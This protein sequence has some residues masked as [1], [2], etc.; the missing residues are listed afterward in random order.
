ML[1]P[2]ADVPRWY[3]ERKPKDTIAVSH[4][5]D[6]ITWEQ[7]ER[8]ANRR[9]RAFA[10]KGVKPGDFVAIGLPNSNVFFET[11]FAVWKCGATPTSLTW[12]L[13]RGEAAAVLDIL[14]PS[15]VVGGQPDW[16]APNSL[17]ADFVPEGVS[18]EPIDNPV[19]RYWKAMTSGGSTG[20]PKVILDH[21]PAVVDTAGPAALGMPLGASLLNPG[22]LYHN[23]PFIVSHTALFNGG[24]VTGLVK[25]DAEECLRLI[26]AS[27]VQWVNFVPT[28]MH[29]I[30]AL[31][32]EVRNRYDLSSLQI[33]FHMAAPMPPWLKE[34]W[35]EWLG[36][37]RIYE[38]YGG[39]EAQGAT[40]ISGV[41][42]LEHRGSVGKIGETARLRI[43][44][45]DG[46]E[47]ATGE[48]GEI[49]FLPNDGAGST[50][51]YLGAEPKRRADGWESLGDIGRLDADG[52]LY[53]GDRL[54][55]MILRGGAN[56]YPAEVE[57]AVT[58]H[59]EVRSCVVVGLPDP[60][61]GQRVHAILELD[62]EHRRASGR[63]RHG[64]VPGRPAQPLQASGKLRGRQRRPARQ[65]RQGPPHPA[66]RRT[67]RLAEGEPR[68]SGSCRRGRGRTRNEANRKGQAMSFRK[69]NKDYEAW[70]AKQCDVVKKDIAYKH[71]RMKKSPF[72]FLRATYFRWARKIGD[73]C[74][75][76]MDAPQLLSIG[77]LHLEN[78]GTWR[79]ADG[80]LVWGVNDFDEAAVMPY[81]LDLVRLVT[82][83]QL[84]PHP[85]V[86]PR[87]AANAVLRG[88]R[89]GLEDPQPTLL[90]EGQTWMRPYAEPAKG[91]PEKF[92]N[93]VD[94]YE[95][96]APPPRIA[97][98]LIESLPNGTD[99]KSI[100]LC[101][102]L[103]KGGGS[104]GR[105]RYVAVGYWRGGQVLREAK[106]LVPSAWNWAN[107]PGKS[108]K[109]NFL[110][111][112][113]SRYRAPDPFLDVRHQFIF[114]R[115]AADS[116]KDRT[117]R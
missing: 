89:E 17:P 76:L 94:D 102:L 51:H 117:G 70:L 78:F 52:Y 91:K 106:A 83:I 107:G 31:P 48:T 100:R 116:R 10:A 77:D 66:A 24:R 36:P 22:P 97:R 108:R 101:R 26:E 93:D 20:R 110:A 55:D 37:E 56:I 45:E 47:V 23:A 33:V 16:N 85:A 99:K 79:D 61:F 49:Y 44:G 27:R 6:A 71:K 69:D 62:R 40:I 67:R 111:L 84:A 82:S 104:L 86:D 25:F 38:L 113:N 64:R 15:L 112:A 98:A 19:A 58:E 54:A 42:W 72:I 74:P 46:N 41:E 114:R 29:R 32:D 9:A 5:A 39:T 63:R 109:S 28:M 50:Y 65:F 73:W 96:Y 43:I 11:T 3:A 81:V 1:I 95:E 92:W 8:N 90:F 103:H 12:R 57:A 7:L 34:K 88:Y 13:P 59:P 68:V 75:E 115:I 80:R 14:K 21:K 18:D 2:I 60:E 4:G 87:R 35:I 30:W 105:P 53:L